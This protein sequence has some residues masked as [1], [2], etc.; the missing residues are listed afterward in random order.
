MIGLTGAD[1]AICLL[2]VANSRD[3]RHAMLLLGSVETLRKPSDC[4]ITQ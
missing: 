3:E 4:E 1:L 2:M